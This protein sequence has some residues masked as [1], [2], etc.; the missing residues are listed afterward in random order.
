MHS[1]ALLVLVIA[2]L[3]VVY[4]LAGYPF[5][6][7]WLAIFRSRPIKPKFELRTVTILLPVHNGAPW[8]RDK[9]E[10]I[11]ALDYPAEARQILVIS[12]GSED[13]T[14]DIV[15][16]YA[17]R[18]VELLR[19][20]KGGKAV[21]LNAGI[22]RA[23]GEVLFF[24]DVRQRLAPSGLKYLVACLGDPSVG[25]VSGELVIQSG[26]THAE[27]NTGLYWRFEK[28]LRRRMSQIDSF[29]G[30]T[31]CIYAMRRELAVPM[32]ANTLIDDVYLPIAAFFRGY[33]V[34]WIQEAKAFDYPSPTNVEYHRKVRTQAGVYQLLLLYPQLLNPFRN[35]MWI[36]FVSHKLGRLAMPF[37]LLA[38][39]LSSFFLPYPW[40]VILVGVEAFPLFLAFIDARVSEHSPIKGLTALCHTFV[41]LMLSALVAV[42]ILFRPSKNFW[43]VTR[44]GE[45]ASNQAKPNR[46]AEAQPPD[47]LR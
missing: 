23:R 6:L 21:A 30:A 28:H 24:T 47:S 36:H 9:L 26:S 41:V 22:E 45:Q 43:T 7:Y 38:I 19:L 15:A 25:V 3:G 16:G 35:R 8:I 31:G 32:P 5:L 18:G 27:T 17:S 13:G 42:T 33:R 10:S 29:H 20:P 11:L 37:L 34:I 44:I 2:S 40:N 14:E 4:V 1:V 46:V 12:D 39:G